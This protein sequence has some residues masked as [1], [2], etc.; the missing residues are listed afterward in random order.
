MSPDSQD[1]PDNDKDDKFTPTE[2][3]DKKDDSANFLNKKTGEYA[4]EMFMKTILLVFIGIGFAIGYAVLAL[5][6][7]GGLCVMDM[8]T[9]FS[10]PSA[11][12]DDGEAGDI[13]DQLTEQVTQCTR[14]HVFGPAGIIAGLIGGAIASYPSY[15]LVKSMTGGNYLRS[16]I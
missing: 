3:S 13:T 7:S 6:A 5:I 1:K 11:M 15:K 4:P 2:S 10:D 14:G 8:M 16:L 9:M 12:A